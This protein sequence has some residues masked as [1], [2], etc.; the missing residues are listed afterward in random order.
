MENYFIHCMYST[1]KKEQNK[2]YYIQKHFK[3][4]FTENTSSL[5][6]K[7]EVENTILYNNTGAVMYYHCC[8]ILLP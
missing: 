2:K 4:I 1:I 5:L 8:S 3:E 6:V 7:L